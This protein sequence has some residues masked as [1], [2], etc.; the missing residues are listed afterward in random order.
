MNLYL[1]VIT[2]D[3]IVVFGA[4]RMKYNDKCIQTTLK[5]PVSVQVCG[6]ISNRG[7][8]LLRELN[9][10]MD[11]ANYQSQSDIIND[12]EMACECVLI[13]Q[14]GNIVMHVLA[15]YHN[16]KSK[17]TFIECKEIPV[18]D[19]LENLPDIKTIAS[20]WNIMQKEIGNQMPCK[21]EDMWKQECEAWYSVAPNVQEDIFNSKP[22]RIAGVIKAKECAT[23][24]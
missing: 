14:K 11:S 16:T 21:K 12:I 6:A 18:L 22:K 2:I 13:P 17:R 20:I 15:P 24:Y 5:S 4:N 1:A 10:N 3:A 7:I 23:K 19:W 9:G 8:S